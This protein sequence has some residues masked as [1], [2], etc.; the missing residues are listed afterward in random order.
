MINIITI[1]TLCLYS[2]ST[3]ATQKCL[4]FMHT[5]FQAMSVRPHSQHS[6]NRSNPIAHGTLDDFYGG[7][8]KRI[9]VV[10]LDFYEQMRKE[11]CEFS[12]HDFFFEP[13]NYSIRT[14]PQMEWK[15]ITEGEG[16]DGS[17]WVM[18]KES[19][20]S[21]RQSVRRRFPA[22]WWNPESDSIRHG[23][24]VD[25]KKR[26]ELVIASLCKQFNLLKEEL[27]AIILFTGPMYAVYNAI[28]SNYPET[29]AKAFGPVNFTTTI[30]AIISAIQ[31]LSKVTEIQEKPLYRG[32]GGWGYLPESFWNPQ[33]GLNVYG[34][35]EFGVMSTTSELDEALRYSGVLSDDRPHP[36]VLAFAAG[37]VDRG[38]C[39]E[40]LS[41]FPKE[42]EFTF[43]PCSY[44]QPEFVDGKLKI[45]YMRHPDRPDVEVP[46]IY[47]RVNA[48]IRSPTLDEL[49]SARKQTHLAVFR[50]QNRDTAAEIRKLCN[51]SPRKEV[52]LRRLRFS[53][54]SG[55]TREE[56][57][58]CPVPNL[59][60]DRQYET[61][62]FEGFQ[63]VISDQC[64][65][66]LD[67]HSRLPDEVFADKREH[68]RL[69]TEM[70][71]VRKWA[72]AKL[73]W[74]IEDE[75]LGAGLNPT[76]LRYPLPASYR[77][78]V[79][80]CRRGIKNCEIPKEKCDRAIKLC[81]LIGLLGSNVE[82][83]PPPWIIGG[84]DASSGA[85]YYV[86]TAT[87]E[88]TW[89][90]PERAAAAPAA[91][92]APA[93]AG[94]PSSAPAPASPAV[95]SLPRSAIIM[96]VENGACNQ[97]IELMLDTGLFD[98]NTCLTDNGNSLLATAVRYGFK[99]MA[100][101]L[102]ERGADVAF[103]NAKDGRTP[104]MLARLRGHKECEVL[105]ERYLLPSTPRKNKGYKTDGLT[106]QLETPEER[107][108]I[109]AWAQ[110]YMLFYNNDALF[111]D[112]N[113]RFGFKLPYPLRSS[114]IPFLV[115]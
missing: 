64:Q 38:A 14:C 86:N 46:V 36:A 24:I 70:I 7:V 85:P 47:V 108:V 101:L 30:H 18:T 31:K 5:I 41:Q 93:P 61:L 112:H 2:H 79:T 44:I 33:G 6:V 13:N 57:S 25:V 22:L 3:L 90:K 28:L 107:E 78:Y 8:D 56:I 89:T 95:L 69:V 91:A 58:R 82:D 52:F 12:G 63:L 77:E 15:L 4:F 43:P 62:L 37:A 111:V 72:I 65:V 32:L 105:L 81:Q 67:N 20:V 42:V 66:Y 34:Y 88:R 68:S 98:I 19:N 110:Q 94:P 26:S 104:L 74:F 92:P 9:G 97:D 40:S 29:L 76:L 84:V 55:L 87:G 48:N 50:S 102:L 114:G 11:H 59:L 54:F 100:K 10:S 75:E 45:E 23:D 99:E 1:K 115:C 96:A 106:P 109:Y 53:W 27:V 51:E 21:E 113:Q 60:D 73:L 17:E 49:N 80:F 83:L 16:A 35:T 103:K 71:S 39:V